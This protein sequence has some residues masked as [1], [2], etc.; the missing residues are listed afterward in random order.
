M[1]STRLL[2]P[3][4][5]PMVA[6]A[7]LAGAAPVGWAVPL[8]TGEVGPPEGGDG[9]RSLSVP[10]LPR[11]KARPPWRKIRFVSRLDEHPRFSDVWGYTTP[12]GVRYALLGTRYGI[13][14]I[15][16]SWPRRPAQVAFLER[17][18]SD[19]RDMKTFGHHAYDVNEASGG[20]NVTDLTD[21]ENPVD[22]PATGGFTKAHNLYVDEASARLYVAGADESGGGVR[23]YDLSDPAHPEL[24]GAWGGAYAHDVYARGDRL[25]ASGI[26]DQPVPALYIVDVSNPA[27]APTLGTISGYPFAATH[28]AWLTQDGT[29]VLVTDEIDGGTVRCWNVSDPTNPVLADVLFPA[30]TGRAIP[31]NVQVEGNLAFISYYTAGV[32]VLD[33]SD[34]ADMNVVAWWDTRPTTN[35]AFFEGAWGVYAHFPAAP[36]LVLVSD[37][38]RG[39]HVLELEPSVR[40][41]AGRT[42]IL[43]E[44]I[45]DRRAG[46][47]G[48]PID[49]DPDIPAGSLRLG[50]VGPNP[51]RSGEEIAFE[52][53]SGNG[54]PLLVRIHDSRGRSVRT[55]LDEPDFAGPR[56]LRWDGRNADGRRVAAG[57]YFVRAIGLRGADARAVTVLR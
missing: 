1:L 32:Q 11:H 4:L 27:V 31:H 26:Q 51:M 47:L 36:D 34:P 39:L 29:H 37:I 18:R 23:I 12:D 28:N 10:G 40:R 5:R 15:D 13:A 16:L 14:I 33:V 46:R 24:A 41:D 19:W 54:G 17:P 6:L 25:Y 56:T 20:L 3:F 42:S 8:P 21:P 52:I 22:V 9:G 43:P 44:V 30:T 45:E 53:N 55:L 2:R 48:G 57:T 35:G 49:G 50:R 38:G 7:L